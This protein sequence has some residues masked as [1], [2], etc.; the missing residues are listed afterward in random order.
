MR[1]MSRCDDQS[2]FPFV[3]TVLSHAR[4]VLRAPRLFAR[5]SVVRRRT[6]FA[7]CVDR[8]WRFG[9]AQRVGSA[10]RADTVRH[11]S[12]GTRWRTTLLVVMCAAMSTTSDAQASAKEK[13]AQGVRTTVRT[14]GGAGG[15]SSA[16]APGTTTQATTPKPS[17]APPRRAV[18]AL[19][20]VTPSSAVADRGAE[21][22]VVATDNHFDAPEQVDAGLV[23]IRLVNRGKEAHHILLMKISRLVRLSEIADVLK[24]NDWSPPWLQALGGPESVISGAT[25]SASFILEPGRYVIA[26]VVGSPSSHRHRFMEGMIQELAVV[27][28]GRSWYRTA[29]P[30][31]E[32]TVKLNEWNY[33]V[34]GPI[35]AG[36]R[37]VRVVNYGKREHQVAFVR[38]LPGRTATDAMHWVDAPSGAPP[39]EVAGGTTGLSPMESVNLDLDFV[40]GE[41][42]MLCTLYDP[43]GRKS[44]LDM[45][46]VKR[47]VIPG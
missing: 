34:S 40:P 41:Y 14:S 4:D 37:T 43:L 23:N 42:L 16:G 11:A 24:E 21:L 29:L 33:E 20:A 7:E 32:V 28:P 46:M 15:V 25:S 2:V 36:R 3:F 30:P 26:C 47:V 19:T 8:A 12:A 1:Q 39:F 31:A 9:S 27:S 44:H 22:V 38:L 35:L 10:Q 17:D 18:P 45:G 6:H 5:D 13:R